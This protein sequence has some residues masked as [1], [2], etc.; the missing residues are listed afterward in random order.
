LDIDMNSIFNQSSVF[1]RS[2]TR[3]EL[4]RWI[5]TE[6]VNDMP[7]VIRVLVDHLR[8]VDELETE[9]EELDQRIVDSTNAWEKAH[10][11]GVNAA[12]GCVHGLA[13]RFGDMLD[14]L[15]GA[16]EVLLP[17]GRRVDLEHIDEEN[18][19]DT[20]VFRRSDFDSF[21]D[22]CDE[23]KESLEYFEASEYFNEPVI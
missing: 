3:D 6:G 19:W 14:E 5:E 2:L 10:E 4:L 15:D 18:P 11:N 22:D 9:N 17:D 16:Y 8:A 13:K 20:L 7:P 21:R 23:L 1:L 12:N